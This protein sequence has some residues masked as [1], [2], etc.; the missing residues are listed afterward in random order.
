MRRDPRVTLLCY[1]PRQPLRYLE[2]RGTV[3]EMTEDGAAAAPRRPRVAST[4][5]A[6]PLL[7]RRH[8]DPRSPRPRSPSCAGSGR[9]ASSRVDASAP[10][11]AR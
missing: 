8:P 6:G 5:A 10:E 9:T 4:W 11:P 3:V 2:I 7:R 1:D